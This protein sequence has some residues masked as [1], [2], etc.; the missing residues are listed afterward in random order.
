MPQSWINALDRYNY[1]VKLANYQ[2]A[3]NFRKFFKRQIQ[4][5]RNSTIAF[6]DYFRENIQ[7]IEVWCEVVFW[8][9][10]SQGNRGNI[11]T[12]RCWDF[13]RRKN[14]TAKELYNAA[15]NFIANN[16]KD[17]F[18]K[19][20]KLWPFYKSRVIAVIATPMSFLVP[21]R[22]PM[23]DTRVAKWI[24]SQLNIHNNDHNGP[25]LIR[26]RYGQTTSTVLTMVDFDFYLH[27]VYWARHTA[28]K[29][30][31]QTEM[32]WRARDVEMAVFTAW[33]DKGCS[34]P[35]LSLHSI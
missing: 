9:L 1:P 5:D 29:L 19:Y 27:W 31:Q 21:D 18:N 16:D 30:S 8:K 13:W 22:F 23:V 2:Y 34:H 17:S 25:Q 15:N 3:N 20:R 10:Y 11:N 35:R 24:D 12:K 26:S 7:N 28:K 33:G 4:G 6:E 32:K 14:I